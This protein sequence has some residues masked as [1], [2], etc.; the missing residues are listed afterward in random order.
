MAGIAPRERPRQRRR[1][2]AERNVAAI[3]DAAL[4]LL[5]VH[6]EASMAEIAAAAGV[7]RQTV[8]AHY[9]SRESLLVAAA[10]RA[11]EQTLA[12][13]DGAEPDR[14]P[15]AEA[16]DRLV[17]AWW[18]RV[19]AHAQVLEALAVAYPTF[20]AVHELHAP[21]IERLM[22]L[23]RRGQRAKDFDR[24]LSPAWLATAF[25]ALMHGA[26][27]EVAAGRTDADE[28]G[29]ALARTIPRLFGVD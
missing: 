24:Q 19:A 5:A 15:P 10:E 14:G 9:E 12:A 17:E 20:E 27:D 26:A 6:P 11:R 18:G 13:I 1:A 25:L 28:A 2:D 8:Y 16:L 29:R 21:I 4:E 23:I 7:S 3:L 22:R